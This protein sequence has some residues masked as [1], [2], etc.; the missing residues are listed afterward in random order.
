MP[1]YHTFTS[2]RTTEPDLASLLG[3]ARALDPTVGIQHHSGTA[4]Y[5]VKKET[6]WTA[7]QITQAQNVIDTAP[8]ATPQLSAQ[9]AV[10]AYPIE[11][12]ALLLTL[13]D[14]INR[15]RTQPTTVFGTIT[16]QQALDA[17]R[18]KAGTLS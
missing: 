12:R 16:V 3:Q 11:L 2:V 10:D 17:V 6:V 4:I 7:P 18:N 1:D 13:L 14:E 8:A 15:L 5:I 9:A